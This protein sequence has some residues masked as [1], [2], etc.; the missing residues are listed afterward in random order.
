MAVVIESASLIRG[1]FAYCSATSEYVRVE[2][3]DLKDFLILKF[4]PSPQALFHFVSSREDGL[5]D[6]QHTTQTTFRFPLEGVNNEQPLFVFGAESKGI[7]RVVL[8][9]T[10]SEPL[11]LTEYYQRGDTEECAICLEALSPDSHILQ[12][13]HTF[14]HGCIMD[15]IQKTLCPGCSNSP[16]VAWNAPSEHGTNVIC[17]CCRQSSM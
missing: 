12:C 5:N 8:K 13:G 10:R 16:R 14:C 15:T 17:P 2:N 6:L 11:L 4:R 7:C 3:G 9:E 1:C